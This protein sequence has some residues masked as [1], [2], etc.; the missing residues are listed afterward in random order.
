MRSSRFRMF[1]AIVVMLLA[2]CS[3]VAFAAGDEGEESSLATSELSTPPQSE[4]GVE[5]S[6]ARTA[7]SQTFQLEDGSRETQIFQQPINY[8]D[9][10]GQ[11]KPIEEGLEPADNGAGLTNGANSF[12]LSLPNR[13]G[14]GA[15]RLS[16]DS[17]WVSYRLL[18]SETEPVVLEGDTASYE[19]ENP[20]ISFDLASLA[21]GVK[22]EIEIAGP[23]QPSSFNFELD[24]SSGL[25]PFLAEDGSVEIRSVD[26]QLF[27]VLP[28][29]TISDSSEELPVPTKNVSYV[30]NETSKGHWRLTVEANEEW[31][32]QPDRVWPVRIDPTVVTKTPALD[33]TIRGGS[34]LTSS[35]GCGEGGFQE[36][37]TGFWPT[38]SGSKGDE[39]ARSLLRFELS[40]IPLNASI[41]SAALNLYAPNAAKVTSGVEIHKVTTSWTKK[42]TWSTTNG[43]SK[44]PGG[45]E[46]GAFEAAVAGQVLTSERGSGAGWW[47]FGGDGMNEMVRSWVSASGN[48]NNGLIAKLIDDTPTGCSGTCPERYVTFDSSAVS[49]EADR[50]HLKVVY[51]VPAPASSHV[52]SPTEGQRSAR[53]FKLKANWSG[54]GVVGVTF[55][56][57]EGKKGIFHA[58]PA[59]LVRKADGSSVTWPLETKGKEESQPIYF[60]AAHASSTLRK[61]GGSLQVRAI[62]EGPGTYSTPVEVSVNRFLGGP[63]DAKAPVGPGTVDL[64]TGNLTT[65]HS[66]VSIPGFSSLEFSRTLNSREAGETPNTGVLGRGWKPGVPVEQAGGSEWRGVKLVSESETFE[67][68]TFSYEYAVVTSLEGYELGFEKQGETYVTPPEL[69]GFNLSPAEGGKLILSD[70]E[71]NRTTFE[72]LGGGEYVPTLVSETGGPGNTTQ[73]VYKT[74]GTSKRLTMIIAPSPEGRVCTETNATTNVGCHALT[75][76]YAPAS[77]PGWEAP[78]EYGERLQKITFYAP[79]NGGPW[80]VANYNYNKEG[81]LTEEWDPRLSSLKEKYSYESGGQLKTIT[82]PGQEPWTLQ[83]GTFDEE[84]G[85]GRLITV[86]RPSLSTPSTAQ[87]TIAYG[88]PISGSEAPNQMDLAS[89]SQWGQSDIPVD[90]TAIFPPDQGSEPTNYSHATVYYMDVEGNNVNTA[91]PPGAGTSSPSISTTETDQYGNVVRELSPANRLRVLEKGTEATRKTRWEEL[92]TKRSFGA[93]GTQLEEEWTP[94]H[95]VRLE[96]GTITQAQ[97]HR[98]I[99]YDQLPEGVTLPSPDPHLPTTETTAALVGGSLLDQRVTKTNYNWKLRLPTETIADFGGLGIKTTTVYDETSRLP[100]ERRQPSNPEGGKAGTTKTIY[101]SAQSNPE[102]ECANKPEYANLPCIIEPAAQTSGTGR[103]ELLVKKFKSY[104]AL[105]EPTELIESPGGGEANQ[106]K[107]I[108]VYDAAGRPLSSEIEGG[109]ASVLATE[110]RYSPTLGLPI[111]QCFHECTGTESRATTTSY[112]ALGQVTEYEDA[113]GNVAKTTYDVDGRPVTSS[114]SKGSQTVTYDPV[115]GLPTKLE[116]SAAGTFT[117][118]YDADGNMVERGLPDGLTANTTYNEVDEPTKLAYTKLG[119]TWY[120]E[121][122]ERSIYGQIESDT[123]TFASQVYSYDKDGRLE[124]AL[125]TP[126]GGSCTTR[127]YH[128]DA[129]SNRKSLTTREPGLGG[130]CAPS[131]GSER[132]YEYDAADRLLG[133]GLTYD[134]FGRINSLPAEDA[135][136]HALTT[137]YF[138]N[139][140]V[141]SQTQNGISNAF[142]LDATGRQRQRIQGPGGLEGTEIFHYDSPSDSPTWTERGSTWTRSIG[143]IGGELAAIQESSGTTTLQLTDLHG[144]IAA[145]AELSPTATKLKATFRFDE[146]GNPVSGSA[147]RYGWLGGKGRRTELPSGVIQMGA[148]S[149]VPEIG[150]F[151]S[152]DPVQGGSANAY[153]YS[154]ADPINQSDLNGEFPNLVRGVT[155]AV[156]RAT[157]RANKRGA[158]VTT[159]NTRSGA[160]KFARYLQNNPLYLEN[161]QRKAAQWKAVELQE[162]QQKAAKVAAENVGYDSNGGGC[163]TISYVTGVAGVVI[164]FATGGA[165]VAAWVGVFS[166]SSGTGAFTGSC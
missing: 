94:M 33:C 11:W 53:R 76:T 103:P 9:E 142:Q 118:S 73:M 149:Y 61:K 87:T 56:F 10:E 1:G 101:Y 124:Q 166:V 96:S 157:R 129:D 67:G 160:E 109:G 130:A 31:L 64:L 155:R 100:I 41:T 7:T 113:D 137:E 112:N 39:R 154:N 12:D 50:P 143:G 159:F 22:E 111:K 37:Q 77:S 42:A 128:Y 38:A 74:E 57:R 115:S 3:G 127:L 75:F 107:K 80:E 19:S 59:E 117:A 65:S 70:P 150:R 62:F 30:L 139:E 63:K 89:V 14:G 134:S 29:P 95:Q 49:T 108:A 158:I 5:I 4:P 72:N 147:G 35:G 135:G 27:A 15:V 165:G 58:I 97:L 71:G 17:E 162:M 138:S 21:N 102:H 81:R 78:A 28:A 141:A 156:I 90:A 98:H 79:G 144:D 151:L 6:S 125:E 20:G 161:I 152:P 66:D 119:S 163:G 145:T 106:R 122:L 104:D 46:G 146:F 131:G 26:D 23:G 105:G 123:N 43:N 136:G 133:T 60:D 25:T 2:F 92:E 68:E 24:A 48:A 99:E 86:K 140:M 121:A 44:W 114:D 18:G 32:E 153:D 110:T 126:K 47:T 8:R 93:E 91:S 85:N 52:S 82:P 55:E 88:V 83:Y 51:N 13:V 148:R 120:E 116:D 36:L 34:H 54:S 16:E 164:G 40:S 45:V 132:K 84:E 69:T